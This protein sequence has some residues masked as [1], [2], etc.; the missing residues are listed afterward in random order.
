MKDSGSYALDENKE[1]QKE[2]SRLREIYDSLKKL[3]EG[4]EETQ[5]NDIPVRL[6]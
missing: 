4:T 3:N 1:G 5:E 2:D 6:E